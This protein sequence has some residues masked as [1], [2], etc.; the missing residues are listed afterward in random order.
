V[1]L[2]GIIAST[3]NMPGGAAYKP[4]DVI[5]TYSG[6][7][8]EIANTDAEGRV[9]LADALA[10]A[11]KLDPKYIIDLATLT[12]AC[13]IALGDEAS[14]LIG[15]DPELIAAL[16]DAGEK[17]DDRVWHLPLWDSHRDQVKGVL[18][19]VKNLGHPQGYGGAITAAAFLE[20]FVGEHKWAHLDIAGPAHIEDDRMVHPKG[21]TGAGVRLLVKFLESN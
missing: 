8:I 7:T 5:K 20:H 6:K 12:G 11:A 19:D 17:A 14:G 13:I 9:V 2:V 1:H 15:N 16:E 21:A 3:E 4:G 18:A 10:Y